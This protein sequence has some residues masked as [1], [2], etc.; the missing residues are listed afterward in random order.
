M[1]IRGCFHLDQISG[2]PT[3][4]TAYGMCYYYTVLY[5]KRSLARLMTH[6][7]TPDDHEVV[8]CRLH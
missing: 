2:S 8:Y 6:Y 1:K 4:S 3:P 7:C 5:I